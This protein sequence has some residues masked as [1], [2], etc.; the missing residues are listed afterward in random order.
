M[1]SHVAV[2]LVQFTFGTSLWGELKIAPANSGLLPHV[3]RL[4]FKADSVDVWWMVVGS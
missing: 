4:V 1:L 2:C 3:C